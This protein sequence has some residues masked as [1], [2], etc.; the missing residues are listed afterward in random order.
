M[1]AAVYTTVVM[2]AFSATVPV[3]TEVIVGA[4]FTSVTETVTALVSVKV[5]VPLSVATT[6]KL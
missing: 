5:P 3:E 2:A 4:S 6:L 1:A